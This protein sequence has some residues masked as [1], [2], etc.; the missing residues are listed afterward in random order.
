MTSQQTDLRIINMVFDSHM[1]FKHKLRQEDMARLVAQGKF[2]WSI[3]NENSPMMKAY[4]PMPKLNSS[5]VIK[6]SGHI[7]IYGLKSKM[8]A[9]KVY[10]EVFDDL[11]KTCSRIFN[12]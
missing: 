2:D 7:I 4:V 8:E 3:V 12:D 9:I 1:P 10:N 11:L 6:V 5:V